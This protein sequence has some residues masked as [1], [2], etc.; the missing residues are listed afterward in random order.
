MSAQGQGQIEHQRPRGE[1]EVRARQSEGFKK[2]SQRR[3][4]LSCSHLALVSLE[5]PGMHP[6]SVSSAWEAWE[7]ARGSFTLEGWISAPFLSCV[8][9]VPIDS[10]NYFFAKRKLGEEHPPDALHLRGR[11]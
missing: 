2:A 6:A 8:S 10:F 3:R 4:R 5:A 11:K 1:R 9:W 7:R